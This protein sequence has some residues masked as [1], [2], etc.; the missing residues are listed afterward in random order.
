MLKY[1]VDDV[2]EFYNNNLDWLRNA[3]KCQ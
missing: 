2:R 3:S 1:G